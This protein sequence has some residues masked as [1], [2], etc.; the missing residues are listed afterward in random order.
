MVVYGD[1]S[2]RGIPRYITYQTDSGWSSPASAQQVSSTVIRWIKL[3]PIKNSN[4]ILMLVSDS[5]ATSDINFQRWD[6]SSWKNL[7]EIETETSNIESFT[8]KVRDDLY[9]IKDTTAPAAVTDLS[10]EVLGEGTVKLIWSTPG[11]DAWNGILPCGS[12]YKIVYSTVEPTSSELTWQC[13]FS[14]LISTYGVS[15][16]QKQSIVIADLPY[17]VTW[18]FRLRTRDEA[19]NWSELSNAT[20]L[21]VVVKPAAITSLTALPSRWGRCIELSWISPGDDGWNGDIV[22]GKFRIRYSTYVTSASDFW[23]TGSW[24][25]FQNKFEIEW[26]TNAT[27]YTQHKRRLT[28]LVGGTTYYIRIWTRDENPNNWSY[29]SNAVTC[30]AQVVVV[31]IDVKGYE[32]LSWSTTYNFDWLQANTSSIAAYGLVIENTGN[33]YE[34][35]GVKIDTVSMKNIYGTIWTIDNSSNVWYDRFVLEGVFYNLR[36]ATT[37][38]GT[39]YAGTDDVITDTLIWS[40]ENSK[41]HPPA[42][43]N[44]PEVS[45]GVRIIP[46]DD[47]KPGLSEDEETID[48]R[49]FWFKIITPLATSTN[50]QQTIPVQFWSQE[51]TSIGPPP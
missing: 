31:G 9:W 42:S 4:Q 32:E 17:E 49:K 28:G 29:I 20:T 45:K 35:F 3:E 30:W 15:P 38:Y 25:D 48:R 47:T 50:E 5:E 16:P 6:G 2:Y 46:F 33:V 36:P 14:L 8:I 12:R 19:G 18:Y 34:D 23:N 13:T 24:T 51:N 7:T 26:S 11:D 41:Y 40:V 43:S 37:D 27:P 21:Y 10:G 22:G 1:S 44:Q 39:A